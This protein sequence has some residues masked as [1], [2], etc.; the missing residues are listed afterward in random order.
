MTSH[1]LAELLLRMEGTWLDDAICMT[2]L[3]AH[4]DDGAPLLLAALDQ[5]RR[6][7]VRKRYASA[8]ALVSSKAA[9]E[10]LARWLGDKSV[11]PIAT[12]K[13]NSLAPKRWFAS[14]STARPAR[15][16]SASQRAA[17]LHRLRERAT[18]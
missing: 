11:A 17:N 9:A 6:A 4:G 8:V 1:D 3:A 18:A 16:P 10:G 13:T 12:K 5:A 7:E 2:L 14:G 15:S